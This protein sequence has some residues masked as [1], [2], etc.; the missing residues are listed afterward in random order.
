MD[1]VPFDFVRTDYLLAPHTR[2]R[3]GGP[4]ALALFP[5]TRSD[6]E[7]A[8]HWLVETNM[9]FIIIG[10]GTNM[11]IDD[12]GYPGC[13]LFTIELKELKPLGEHR[14]AVGAGV[15]LADLVRQIMLPNNYEG[16]GALTGIPG[17]VGGALF[18]NA[19]TVNGSV[20]QIA[21]SIDTLKSDGLVHLPLTPDLYGYRGQSF[22]QGNSVIVG[23][24]FAFTPSDKDESAVY[25]H[26]MQRRSE[27]QPEGW[28][29]GSV[30][31]NPPGDHAGKLIEAAG[32]K[33]T[34]RNGAVI[35]EKHA[36]FIMNEANASFDDV[37]YLITLV[38]DT[39]RERFGVELHEEVRIIRP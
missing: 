31:K 29:C 33:G 32:L 9:P 26:Y 36:N 28:C 39:I 30:F 19:G 11:L 7:A 18:M 5:P 16:V 21:S 4:A 25:R 1:T 27:T 8:Y 24:T 6:M 38:K 10:G 23:A 20:C 35:S 3:I 13:A 14:Y 34:R 12:K 15:V 37:L 2:Y 17:T 22:C